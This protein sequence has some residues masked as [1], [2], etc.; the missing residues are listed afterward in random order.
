MTPDELNNEQPNDN[1][2]YINAINE[3]KQNSVSK[4]SYDKL[5]AENKQLLDTLVSGGTI[6][7]I[8]AP[9]DIAKLRKDLNNENITNL[10]YCKAALKLRDAVIAEGGRDPFLPCGTHVSL[11]DSDYAAAEKVAGVLQECI[12]Y[13]Q[14]DPGVFTVELQRRMV[15]AMPRR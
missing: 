6:T 5:R 15:D 3:L 12:D 13:A 11:D 10:D 9:V 4:E 1:I 2:D 7:Q 8:E 14:G